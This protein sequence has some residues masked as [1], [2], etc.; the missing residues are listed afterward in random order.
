MTCWTL[1]LEVM[2][3]LWHAEHLAVKWW[4]YCDMLN[5]A[6]WSDD[7]T[8]TCWT[9]SCEVITAVTCWTFSC[10][11]MAVLWHAEHAEHYIVIDKMWPNFCACTFEDVQTVAFAEVVQLSFCDNLVR[12]ECSR[13]A[14]KNRKWR[15]G[16]VDAYSG[17]V[18]RNTW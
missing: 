4:L 18:T 17:P 2:T 9:F 1:Q 13:K 16:A 3:V 14:G 12:H 6:A 15:T 5:T 8:V 7:C 10:E 11:V